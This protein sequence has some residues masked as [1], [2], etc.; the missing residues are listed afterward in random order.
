M[1]AE[2]LAF[3][4]LVDFI[5]IIII[6]VVDL[7]PLQLCCGST[8]N[9]LRIGI[10]QLEGD[11]CLS[12]LVASA[13]RIVALH[14]KDVAV[15]V[16]SKTG[17]HACYAIWTG[18]IPTQSGVKVLKASVTRDQHA[19]SSWVWFQVCA[20]AIQAVQSAF[21]GDPPS[22]GKVFWH[23]HRD[24]RFSLWGN[25]PSTVALNHKPFG[26]GLRPSC[27]YAPPSP[28]TRFGYAICCCSVVL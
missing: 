15:D 20:P 12:R 1:A 14:L 17:T 8:E 21:V 23:L 25:W 18:T 2:R 16:G 10:L 27:P 5:I 19:G 13:F 28:A 6:I 7:V 11:L 22:I 26:F 4:H 24:A 9:Y 3:S